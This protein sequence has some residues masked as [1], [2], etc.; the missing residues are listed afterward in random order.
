MRDRSLASLASNYD[1]ITPDVIKEAPR[2]E[3]PNFSSILIK[4][5][6]IPFGMGFGTS[7]L[8]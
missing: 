1:G 5:C 7:P 3:M 2:M 6:L 8:A 4:R